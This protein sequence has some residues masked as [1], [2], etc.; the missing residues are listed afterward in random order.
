MC[1]LICGL[2]CVE[3]DIWIIVMTSTYLQFD[4]SLLYLAWEMAFFE[5]LE[6]VFGY[7]II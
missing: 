4:L 5:F 6:C 2:E 7:Y 3:T 1:G